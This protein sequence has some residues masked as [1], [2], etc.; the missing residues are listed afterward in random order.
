MEGDT[1]LFENPVFHVRMKPGSVQIINTYHDYAI[2]WM[3]FEGQEW[4]RII[5]QQADKLS[6]TKR[7]RCHPKTS[8][9][10]SSWTISAPSL[11]PCHTPAA[12]FPNGGA[13]GPSS[14]QRLN[15]QWRSEPIGGAGLC[16]NS[17]S[18]IARALKT[19]REQQTKLNTGRKPLRQHCVANA[20]IHGG[21]HAN[22]SAPYFASCLAARGRSPVA[23][24]PAPPGHVKSSDAAVTRSTSCF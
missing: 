15:R 9:R 24:L 13:A 23:A 1:V 16:R 11:L 14:R 10:T 18:F 21:A 3:L 12:V 7:E 4:L 2:T 19:D 8:L 5:H 20:D 22:L 6:S 17:D